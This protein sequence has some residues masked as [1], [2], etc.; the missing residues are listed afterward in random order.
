M[1]ESSMTVS[2]LFELARNATDIAPQV[3]D[4]Y[5]LLWLNSLEGLIYTGAVRQCGVYECTV[6]EGKVDLSEIELSSSQALPRGC[7]VRAV[8]LN[9]RELARVDAS[10]LPRHPE[11]ACFYADGS[12]LY[13]QSPSGVGGRAQ[14]VYLCRPAVKTAQ[15]L[16][17][18]VALPDEFLPMALDYLVGCAYALI[19]EDG[20]AA[21]RFA[22]YNAAMEEFIEWHE[23]NKGG[24]K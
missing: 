6:S 2:A 14:V 9:G 20:Q 24:N 22:A 15:D 7:D 5:Y 17:A 16:S 23:K 11:R 1:Y 21:N 8:Y 13:L 12:T 3:D 18:Y 10:D 19:C 4:E